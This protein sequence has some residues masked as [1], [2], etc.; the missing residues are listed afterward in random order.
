MT[1]QPSSDADLIASVRAGDSRAFDVLYRRHVDSARRMA[2][3]L[4]RDAADVDDLVAEAFAR[5]LAVMSSGGGPDAAFRPY[6][7]TTIRNLFYERVRQERRVQVTDDPSPDPVPFVDTALQRQELAFVAQAFAKLPER[8]QAVLWHTEVERERPAT[9]APLLGLSPNGV[10]ALA[11][12]AREGLRQQYL[13]EHLT[14]DPDDDCRWTTE[15]LGAYV[16]DGLARREHAKVDEHLSACRRCH[17]LF[18]E[19]GEVSSG[20]REILAAALLSG[21]SVSG[22]ATFLAGFQRVIKRRSTQAA[23]VAAAILA[24][25][26]AFA[27]MSSS[28]TPPPPSDKP[29]LAK[30]PVAQSPAPPLEVPS[31]PPPPA[32][33]DTS[34]LPESFPAS[35][36]ASLEPVG[37]LVRG[38]PGALA[39]TVTHRTERTV[40]FGPRGVRIRLPDTGPLTARLTVPAGVTV[41]SGDPGDGWTCEGLVC[42]RHALAAGGTTKAFIPVDVS[43]SA[44]DGELKVHLSA[45][46]ATATSATTLGKVRTGGL[47]AGFAATVPATVVTAGNT[48]MSCSRLPLLGCLGHGP[49][50]G[51]HY[52]TG[53]RD[54]AAPSGAPSGSAVSGA[55]LRLA[56]E[57]LWA[58]LYWA[59]TGNTAA[60]NVHLRAP[61]ADR[62]HSVKADRVDQV[63]DFPQPAYQASAEV[64]GLVR[65]GGTFWVAGATGS[66]G[67]GSFGGWALL[68]VV[69]TAGPARDVTVLE[70]VHPLHGSASVTVPLYGLSKESTRLAFIGW[71]GDRGLTGDQLR[72]GEQLLDDNV[73]SSRTDGTA[74]GWNTYGVDARVYDGRFRGRELTATSAGDAWILGVIALAPSP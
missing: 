51:D 31:P 58:K 71:E 9:V 42:R 27:L 63:K 41:S 33:P 23:A 18:I 37:T 59:G 35:L 50:N 54:P 60:P 56:G 73:A 22:G 20:M 19:L 11:Y 21:Y 13:Q 7:L 72:L 34:P 30:P 3:A 44:A 68:V 15:R 8:W 36:Q 29:P 40:A 10:A 25:A 55:S 26:V 14:A 53:Y 43:A 62:F 6:L 32:T 12:R 74:Q 4:A 57:V 64:T 28:S 61:D 66:H 17:V 45:P 70:G 1:D 39:M 38:R 5:L 24:A 47:S 48:L 49:D 2:R 52:M 65:T 16:R 46:N 69:K 67:V